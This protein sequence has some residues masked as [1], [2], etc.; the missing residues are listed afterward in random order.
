MNNHLLGL[1]IHVIPCKR[2]LVGWGQVKKHHR[3]RISKKW[4]KRYGQYPITGPC[5]LPC[6]IMLGVCCYMC[7]CVLVELKKQVKE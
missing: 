1:D 7:R 3:S 4:L 2:P 6:Y 5:E